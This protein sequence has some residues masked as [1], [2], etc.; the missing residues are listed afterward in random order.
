[1]AM[2]ASESSHGSWPQQHKSPLAMA[3]RLRRA[4]TPP[5]EP[6]DDCG[7]GNGG[8]G[9]YGSG[10]SRGEGDGD[11]EEEGRSPVRGAEV[12]GAAREGAVNNNH[13]EGPY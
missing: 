7:T 13:A 2:A 1:M 8:G 5:P 3:S 6:D 11:W 9:G 10:D 4:A 12:A